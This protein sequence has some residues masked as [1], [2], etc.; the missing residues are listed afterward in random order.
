MQWGVITHQIK[1]IDGIILNHKLNKNIFYK[2]FGDQNKI[3]RS[4]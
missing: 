3:N 1:I 4:Y 2:I